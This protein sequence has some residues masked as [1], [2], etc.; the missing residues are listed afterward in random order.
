MSD[1]RPIAILTALWHRP[2]VARACLSWMARE[3][4]DA[5]RVAVGSL[6][7]DSGARV[8]AG[9]CGWEYLD[10]PNRP[11]SRKWQAGLAWIGR[12]LDVSAVM[13]VGSDDVV[14]RGAFHGLL[15]VATAH[16]HAAGFPDMWF[17]SPD[18]GELGY[19]AGPSQKTEVLPSCAPD[20]LTWGAGRVYSRALLDRIE[21]RLWCDDADNCL[22][23]LADCRLRAVTDPRRSTIAVPMAVAGGIAVD[24]KS[25]TNI[26]GWKS[27]QRGVR[28]N[29]LRG[30]AAQAMLAAYQMEGLWDLRKAL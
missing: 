19:H 16:K 8:L 29:T 12:H 7:G 11:L 17:W 6:D 4:P 18:A 26:W 3:Y 25:L 20:A 1:A 28:R 24:T 22:D 10:A 9:A 27:I 13:T 5:V 14:T 30:A 15:N 21:W 2:D 23:S